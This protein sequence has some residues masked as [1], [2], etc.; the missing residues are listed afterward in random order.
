M[1]WTTISLTPHELGEGAR[2]IDGAPHW[3]NLLAGELY[4][5]R[6]GETVLVRKEAA[7]LGFADRATER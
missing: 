3:V 6:D 1:T 5:Y 2:L 7:P 4:A